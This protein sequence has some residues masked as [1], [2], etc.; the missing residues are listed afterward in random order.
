[1]RKVLSQGFIIIFL[2]FVL[3]SS[4]LAS[5]INLDGSF[6]FND[7]MDS[8]GFSPGPTSSQ[9]YNMTYIIPF[10]SNKPLRG[11]MGMSDNMNVNSKTSS[12][13]TSLS[14]TDPL[15]SLQGNHSEENSQS[16]GTGTTSSRNDFTFTFSPTEKFLPRFNY[17]FSESDAELGGAS[18]NLNF[19]ITKQIRPGNKISMD[20]GYAI[21]K[22]TDIKAESETQDQRFNFSLMSNPFSNLKF[23]FTKDYGLNDNLSS[24]I[25]QSENIRTSY[26]ISLNPFRDQ[27]TNPITDL[28]LAWRRGEDF[29]SS[30][31]ELNVTTAKSLSFG[32][33]PFGKLDL[34]YSY[35]IN[36]NENEKDV[37]SSNSTSQSFLLTI[38]IKLNIDLKY[39]YNLR[40]SI[41][42]AGFGSNS[43]DNG[44]NLG[45]TSPL[46]KGSNLTLNFTMSTDKRQV[47]TD[48]STN[49][50]NS[51][52]WAV[53]GRVMILKIFDVNF[54]HTD[55][56]TKSD[57]FLNDQESLSDSLSTSLQYA[58][59]QL[60]KGNTSFS[61]NTRSSNNRS[62]TSESN[63]R[64]LSNGL[65]YQSGNI[66]LGLVM[67][68]S[69]SETDNVTNKKSLSPNVAYS[70]NKGKFN[71]R[72]ALTDR[73]DEDPITG[74]LTSTRSTNYDLGYS[75]NIAPQSTFT[76]SYAV[77]NS[78]DLTTE[79]NNSDSERI[80]ASL[81]FRF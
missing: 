23:N 74:V 28:S 67:S 80:S 14:L 73:V 3:D 11:T 20:M 79:N 29:A 15:F 59:L 16:S 35:N 49:E 10:L 55:T 9:S 1:M 40:K 18:N 39:N 54:T 41:D 65:N 72:C 36:E 76:M 32:L 7:G 77:I 22:N 50:Q 27:Y 56:L 4:L 24:T 21:S 64:S 62:Q 58:I 61:Y 34:R 25:S 43:E 12:F 46:L 30:S 5:W 38:P 53:S 48:T 68:Y 71:F 37:S 19:S 2:I 78:I 33:K 47:I 45:Y 42:P 52:N 75:Y 63:D 44:F 17:N 70:L 51:L 31:N 66:T 69:E 26:D 13:R 6:S 57:D 8:K 60:I 81:N